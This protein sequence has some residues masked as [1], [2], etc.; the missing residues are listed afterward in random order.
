MFDKILN[1][2]LR[3]Q[4]EA[5]D[6]LKSFSGKTVR[7]N[8]SQLKFIFGISKT[9]EFTPSDS[10]PDAEITLDASLL[11]HLMRN[12]TAPGE[13]KISG[14]TE[15]A[16]AVASVIKNVKWDI[17]EDLS[18][19]FGD[20]LAHRLTGFGTQFTNWVKDAHESFSRSLVEYWIEEQPLL[21]RESEV[22][23]FIKEVD[24]LREATERLDKKMMSLQKKIRP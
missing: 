18:L 19:V 7:F 6:K 24:S 23:E 15:L 17:E 13:I 8:V 21:V 11:P 12:T 4:P 2:L 9:G 16:A 3:N 10:T 1:H 5:Q 14:D 22:A 20:V